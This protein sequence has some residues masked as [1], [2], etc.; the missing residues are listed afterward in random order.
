M[1]ELDWF[2]HDRF[3]LFVHWGLYALGGRHEWLMNR[4]RI[5]TETYERYAR[6]F[7][8]DLF[9]PVD[10]VR[11][12]KRPGMKYM[13]LT[14]KHHEGFCLWDSKLTDYTVL[15]T[16]CGRDIVASYV[17]AVRAAGL[18]VG[19]YHS[20]LDWHH[21]DFLIDGHH[22]RRDD[23]DADAQ[24][25]GRDPSRYRAYLTAKCMSS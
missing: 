20:L 3:G 23:P 22:P 25:V 2:A 10:W 12:A 8:P 17:E 4:E 11:Q 14:T 15:N 13:V 19:F 7:E 21:S 6:Y 9:D 16:P 18:K 5:R 24:N 1:P